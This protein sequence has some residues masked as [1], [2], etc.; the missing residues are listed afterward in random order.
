MTEQPVPAAAVQPQAGQPPRRAYTAPRLTL[1]GTV[2]GLT[3]G[4]GDIN[5]VSGTPDGG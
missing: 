3:H 5:G 1:H 4:V 2:Q